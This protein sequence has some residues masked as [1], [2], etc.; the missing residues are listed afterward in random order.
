LDLDTELEN[1][2]TTAD[3][4]VE[5]VPGFNDLFRRPKHVT[6]REVLGTAAVYLA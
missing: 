5:D 1:M 6:P 2:A 3:A 4:V